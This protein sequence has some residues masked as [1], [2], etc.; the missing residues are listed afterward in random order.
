[1][2]Q[3]LLQVCH[4]GALHT[5]VTERCPSDN[6]AKDCDISCDVSFGFD[7]NWACEVRSAA[8]SDDGGPDLIRE[9]GE[10]P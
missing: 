2:C 3:V 1:M 6:H 10:G 4:H 7:A 9:V 5:R 8:K